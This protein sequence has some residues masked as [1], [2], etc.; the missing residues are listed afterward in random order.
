MTSRPDESQITYQ[1]G[2][3]AWCI[4]HPIGVSMLTLA[5]VVL[6][7]FSVNRLAVDLLPHI[8]QPE[9][10]VRVNDPGSPA[11]IIED[12]ITKQ[13]EEQLAITEDAI[14]VESTSREG[15]SL[16]DL[17]FAFNKDINLA[18]RDASTRLDRAR[19]YLPDTID[20]PVIYK[21]DPSQRPVAE[22]VVSSDRLDPVK[23]RTWVDDV[24]A[25]WFLNLPGV[26]AAEVGGGLVR[27]I[28]ILPDQDRLAALGLRLQDLVDA[29]RDSNVAIP[30]GR[31]RLSNQLISSRTD[32]RFTDV[33]SISR[34]PIALNNGQQVLLQD[35]AKVVDS[36]DEEVLR[37][38]LDGIPGIKVSIQKQPGANT[39]A[40][41]DAVMRRLQQ[42]QAQ[43]VIPP[44]ITVK[45][46]GD[47]S[48]YIR[49]ALNNASGATLS[50]ALLAMLVVY[51]FLGNLRR[52]LVIGSAIPIAIMFTFLLM[53]T[54][55]LTL[56]IMTLGG[57]A[58][59]VGM[60]VDN[61]IV[62]LE[63]QYRHQLDGETGVE[64]GTRA[65]AEV[66]GAIIASTSTNLAAILPFL[67]IS[68]LVGL[69]F[70]ELIITVSSAIV[71]S[72]VIALTL[73]PALAARIPLV[74]PG[75]LRLLLDAGIDRLRSMMAY[76]TD[77]LLHSRTLRVF[78]IVVMLIMLI[79]AAQ[80]FFSVKQDFLPKLDEGNIRIHINTD[81][82]TALEVTDAYVKRIE[83]LVN[84]LPYIESVFATSGGFVYGRSR[85]ESQH[86]ATLIVQLLPLSERKLSSHAWIRKFNKLVK[87]KRL[88]GVRVRAR[89][90]GIRGIPLNRGS[91]E[92]SL[93]V[94]GTDPETLDV[95]ADKIVSRLSEIDKI[96]N[97]AS[98]SEGQRQEVSIEI[99]RQR[100]TSLNLSAEQIGEA[101]RL[102]VTGL[103]ISEYF[104]HG[105]SFD[106]RIKLPEAD[107][108]RIDLL[109]SVLLEHTGENRQPVYLADV[110]RIQTI[111]AAPEILRENQQ[112]FVEVSAS[113]KQGV[114]SGEIEQQIQDK[115]RT[116]KLPDG[117]AIYDSGISQTLKE[118]RDLSMI[119]L[120]L[121]LFLVFTVIAIQ[122][123]SLTNPIVILLGI[124]FAIIGVAIG[125][126]FTGLNLT[127]I[128]WLGLIM[129]A[130]I[131]VNN[132]IVLL[133]YIEL[134]RRQ[135]LELNEAITEAVRLR[136]RPILMT[137]LTTIA[138]LTPLAN[139][140]GE[141]GEMLRPLAV[142]IISGLS[143]SLVVSLVLIPVLYQL[144]HL[145]RLR[146]QASME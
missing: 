81:I 106:I 105:R 94:Q 122:Y 84:T 31:L 10:R 124:P 46:V 6:G 25:K 116:I 75:K 69:L 53:D 41:V 134:Q 16:V 19:R 17:S 72:M 146:K 15:R 73:V 11:S 55:G 74:K 88:A 80:S 123:E 57:L 48:V 61:T 120:G 117:Y 109:K 131:V 27:E 4:R 43:R 64:T 22:F 50:G 63:N 114:S 97:V 32:A 133:E 144:F 36:H 1:R 100:A 42:L 56:N 30:A 77:R 138:G 96:R 135:G 141:G 90:S 52:T 102:A 8:I 38:R 142:T 139:A 143:F 140:W 62:M 87:E 58:V 127:M 111:R 26:A 91:D 126:K 76:I 13:L 85:W 34:L 68:G 89:L 82:G 145:G 79:P 137:T 71:A 21:R 70:R 65:A 45:K 113:L 83:E 119:L 9:V 110:A 40:V 132:A 128:V 39:V 2:L 104:E 101:A 112:R 67:F 7:M 92:V 49:H 18:L 115:L 12:Q 5:V 118:G 47:Q 60:L 23:L 29:I 95:V 107:I 78:V 136:L 66:Q 24:F 28:Q 59:G 54:S 33:E 86:H 35:L 93:R 121:A 14:A 99:D 3:T 103:V 129:L 108:E 37:I 98:S 44:D 125:L 51:L 20:P 130:G